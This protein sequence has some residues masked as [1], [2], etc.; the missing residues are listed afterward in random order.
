[1]WHRARRAQLPLV[2]SACDVSSVALEH[3]EA[4]ARREGA[5]IH[6]FRCDVLT[7]ELLADQDALVCSLFL[8]HLEDADAIALLSRMKEAARH[9]VLVND[10]RR[11]RLCHL[12]ARVGTLLLT[13]S[14]VVHVD[15]PRSVEGA[16]TPEEALELARRAGLEGATV[17]RRWPCRFLLTW[18]RR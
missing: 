3:A 11:G 10:L 6:F 1:L 13:R 7:E 2:L 14:D 15:G 5:A 12:L 9:L 18:E 8:H 4:A 17:S 16:F